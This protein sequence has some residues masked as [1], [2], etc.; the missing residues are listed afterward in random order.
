MNDGPQPILAPIEALVI[1]EPCICMFDHGPDHAE[2]GTMGRTNLAD[3][4]RNAI[5]QAEGA[6][7]GTV[8]PRIGIQPPDNSADRLGQTHQIGKHHGVVDVGGRRQGSEWNAVGRD[9]H[10]VLRS[11]LAPVGG[12]GSG[13]LAAML[14]SDATAVHNDVPRRDGGL[15]SRARHPDQ[16]GMDAAEKR[17]AIPVHETTAQ[18]RTGDA[19]FGRPHF[20]P[21]WTFSQEVPQSLHHPH[22]RRR[23]TSGAVRWSLLDPV[24][25]ARYKLRRRRSHDRLPWPLPRVTPFK[26]EDS[27]Q[28]QNLVASELARPT[29]W[30]P[31]L[32]LSALASLVRDELMQ[33]EPDRKAIW[34]IE[35]DLIVR[36]D[37]RMFEAVMRNL[38][39]NAWKYSTHASPSHVRFYAEYRAGHRYFCVAD[40]GA[41]FD[42]AHSD[43]LF[44]PFQRLHRQDEFPGLG[45][46][47]AT[48][49]RIIN[50]HGGDILASASPEQGAQFCFTLPA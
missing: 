17:R 36:G 20:P 46:G 13:Q 18:G 24:D 8:V 26:A 47:L 48:V 41:G 33:T 12:I 50:R 40:N 15:R 14:G 5:A 29:F 21:L 2:T 22:R 38:L 39:G 7:V 27:R 34:D 19:I 3:V 35:P 49:K 31:R 9:D 4:G 6:V 25:D 30:K 42:M 28:I 37:P 16:R 10:V 32:N 44:K 23:R 11:W 43:L 45:I 1:E